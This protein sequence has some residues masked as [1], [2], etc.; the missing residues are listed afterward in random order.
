MQWSERYCSPTFMSWPLVPYRPL[1]VFR[2]FVSNVSEYP[3]R[4][5]LLRHGTSLSINSIWKS[6]EF[7]TQT[8]KCGGKGPTGTTRYKKAHNHN[9]FFYWC[10]INKV[11]RFKLPRQDEIGWETMRRYTCKWTGLKSG[12]IFSSSRSRKYTSIESGARF[13]W[14][15]RIV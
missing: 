3:K 11:I 7:P 8:E 1:C 10:A 6:I 2:I 4:Y 14:T 12:M 15:D 5:E 9:V 13:V